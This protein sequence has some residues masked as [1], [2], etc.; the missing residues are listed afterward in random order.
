MGSSLGVLARRSH[1]I[2]TVATVSPP[3]Q[4]LLT[5]LL[6]CVAGPFSTI[7]E[8]LG[9]HG[10]R[11][12]AASVQFFRNT[13]SAFRQLDL[14]RCS[15]SITSLGG[16]LDSFENLEELSIQK[17]TLLAGRLRALC[18]LCSVLCALCMHCSFT[19]TGLPR[20]FLSWLGTQVHSTSSNV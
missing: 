14:V 18:A 8:F 15:S 16:V 10:I 12:R 1:K 6:E 17:A 2:A 19:S 7:V 4:L 20:A 3:K 5:L 9:F 13:P 11:L